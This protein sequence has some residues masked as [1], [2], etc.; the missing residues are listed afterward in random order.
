MKLFV[1]YHTCSNYVLSLNMT[2]KADIDI[3]I[4]FRSTN[5]LPNM[6]VLSQLQVRAPRRKV[7]YSAKNLLTLFISVLNLKK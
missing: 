6:T 1:M 5:V 4:T 3:F 7:C 2:V